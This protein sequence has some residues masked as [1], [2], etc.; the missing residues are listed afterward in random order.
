[1]SS[2]IAA[3]AIAE[4]I[5]QAKPVAE[6]AKPKDE[7][8]SAPAR[9]KGAKKILDE[10]R[11]AMEF[12][13][14]QAGNV[15][16]YDP[17]TGAWRQIS[18][19]V[20]LSIVFNM[21][22]RSSASKRR[23]VVEDLKASTVVDPL[24]WGRVADSEI[25]CKN[26]IIDVITGEKRPH[27]PTNLL[28]RVLPIDWDV[29]AECPAWDKALGIWFPADKDGGRRAALQEFFGYI[30]LAHAKYKK[31]AVLLG[32]S[33]TGKSVPALIAKAMVGSD[34]SC[35]LGVEDMD[36][37]VRRALIKGKALNVL[38][39]LSA[40]ALIA[41]GGF[42]TLVSTEEPISINAKYLA[43]ETYVSTA[44]HL[45]VTNN[46]PRFNDHTSAMFNRLLI[47][48]FTEVIPLEQQD[49][50]LLEKL[51]AELPG[52][53][54]WAAKGAERLV[55]RRGQW[56]EV[57]AARSIMVTFREDMNPIRQ[58]MAERMVRVAKALTPIRDI[59]H[60]FNQWNTGSR[61]YG[62]RYVGRLLRACGHAERIR[63][64]KYKGRTLTCIEG[65]RLM[66]NVEER[67][68]AGETT[69][70]MSDAGVEI[71]EGL[72]AGQL[73]EAAA[74]ADDDE[75]RMALRK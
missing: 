51:I 63:E 64:A 53:L 48:P 56:P 43:P 71:V 20:Q 31:A 54:V 65:F 7:K 40:E 23:A 68:M 72:A 59:A 41:D 47:I 21:D 2:E 9:G 3:E 67:L 66:A 8:R 4:K 25:P 42:K 38:T 61:N 45:I 55:R 19:Q 15:Y 26:G 58:F 33:D 1:M 30:A 75:E 27:A 14:D 73:G 22:R 70:V 24:K 44:K 12:I 29:K 5:D 10:I 74:T 16:R 36:D 52:I 49:R 34:F 6:V 46:L 57:E 69:G 50:V 39:E 32:E 11:K 13:T 28:E 18:E 62:I 17:E 60:A 37:P 35:A